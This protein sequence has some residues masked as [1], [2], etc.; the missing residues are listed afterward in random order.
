MGW[1]RYYYP[2][3]F[4][5]A[6]MNCAKNDED[7]Y[8]GTVLAKSKGCK[9]INPKFRYSSSEYGCDGKTKTIYKGLASIKDIGTDTGDNLYSIKDNHYDSFIDVLKDINTHKLC[10]KKELTILISIN[11]FSE[12]GNPNQLLKIVDIYNKFG[13]VKVLTKSKLTPQE[14]ELATKYARKA[15]EKQLREIDTDGLINELIRGIS[16]VTSDVEQVC[17]DLTYL[18]YSNVISDCPYYGVEGV[19]TTNYGTQYIS[20]YNISTGQSETYKLSY[21]WD[22]KCEQGDILEVS[23]EDKPKNRK[24]G[25]KWVKTGEMEK[26]IKLFSIKLKNPKK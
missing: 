13:S 15:T 24:E 20:L 9:I 8:N 10:N 21:K 6:Y 18:G 1:L 11:Y 22:L 14:L 12:F 23:F 19:E 16:D 26:R 17:Y 5:T 4:C 2:T 25:D 7:L 3:E